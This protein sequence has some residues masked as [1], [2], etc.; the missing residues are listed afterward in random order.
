ME[1]FITTLVL[2]KRMASDGENKG[3]S[4]GQNELGLLAMGGLLSGQPAWL[5]GLTVESN[6][7]LIA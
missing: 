6:A 5:L 2:R 1:K 4:H 7:D 3:T